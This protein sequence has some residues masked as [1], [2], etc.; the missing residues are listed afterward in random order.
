MRRAGLMRV[1]GWGGATR[2]A[3]R[4]ADSRRAGPRSSASRVVLA[5]ILGIRGCEHPILQIRERQGKG[6]RAPGNVGKASGR[7]GG[8]SIQRLSE[9]PGWERE[10][11]GTD[12]L[13]PEGLRM[14]SSCFLKARQ[15]DGHQ[16]RGP[17]SGTAQQ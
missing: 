16:R 12:S 2:Q 5:A 9:D 7:V 10:S 17:V 8:A 11:Q 15:G 14:G 6:A 4:S 1:G 3:V 13:I